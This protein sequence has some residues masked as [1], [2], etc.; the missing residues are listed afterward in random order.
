[1]KSPGK[2]ACGSGSG[3]NPGRRGLAAGL[4][5]DPGHGPGH[6]VRFSPAPGKKAPPPDR[7][8]VRPVP[9]LGMAL[10]ELCG[11][12]LRYPHGLYPGDAGRACPL[13]ADRRPVASAGLLSFLGLSGR[14]F[15]I[16]ADSLEKIFEICKNF[17]CICE[18]MG[19]NRVYESFQIS[20]KAEKGTPW[21]TRLPPANM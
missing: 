10:C 8:P 15:R 5:R 7:C 3:G 14:P 18:K 13:G 6:R 1:M 11:V 9:D 12:P 17:V 20:A 19:Y 4:R 16:F 2:A 21:Q